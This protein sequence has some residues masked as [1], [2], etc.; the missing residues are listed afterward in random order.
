MTVIDKFSHFFSLLVDKYNKFK[1]SRSFSKHRV[2]R[3]RWSYFSLDRQ[4]FFRGRLTHLL[5]D[6][7]YILRNISFY[8]FFLM[9]REN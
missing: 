8:D 2:I 1:E 4:F 3:I 7:T 5:L 6:Q 9:T